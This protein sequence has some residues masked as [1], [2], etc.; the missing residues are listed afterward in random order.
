MISY[1]LIHTI[2][3]A[4]TFWLFTLLF[5]ISPNQTYYNTPDSIEQLAQHV[6]QKYY[7]LPPIQPRLVISLAGIPGSG[8]ST[9]A[10]KLLVQLQ[11]LLNTVILPMDGF[12]L[13]R[14]ELEQLSDPDEAFRRRGAPFTFNP[15]GFIDTI[16]KINDPDWATTTIYA[17]SFDHAIKDPV[18]NGIKID[19]DVQVV[20][21]E[22]NY[23]SLKVAVWNEIES[24]VDDTWFVHCDLQLARQRIVSRHVEAGISKDEQEAIERVEGND[25]INARYIIDN[26]KQP[27]V[28]IV[29]RGT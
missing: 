17:P 22:G 2:A 20:I 5:S 28:V 19:P 7:N 24:F 25:L 21:V 11:P 12:H 8:K 9:L 23:V 13:T 15:Q 10:R 6:Q 3:L 29:S 16:K 1:R 4:S 18:D 14:A 27:N 26:S